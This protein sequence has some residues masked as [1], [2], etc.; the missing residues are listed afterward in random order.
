MIPRGFSAGARRTWEEMH[1]HYDFSASEL[2]LL[3][4]AL[5]QFDLGDSFLKTAQRAGVMTGGGKLHPLVNASRDAH[6]N[7]LRCWRAIGFAKGDGRTRRP[8]R[9]GGDEWSAKRK[10]LAR[11][12]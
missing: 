2:I 9:P 5:R 1:E 12:P 6:Q 3:E 10:E 8:G 11:I 4:R 7:A